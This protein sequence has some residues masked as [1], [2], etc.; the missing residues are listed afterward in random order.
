VCAGGASEVFGTVN[1]AVLLVERDGAFVEELLLLRVRRGVIAM[2][3]RCPHMGRALEDARLRAGVLRCRGHGRSYNLRTGRAAGTLSF[4]G[5]P[6]LAKAPAWTE[7]DQVF[8]D[9]AGI[10]PRAG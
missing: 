1:R 7:G 3:N 9:I 10:T 2:V 8:V 5:P 6:R 4:G